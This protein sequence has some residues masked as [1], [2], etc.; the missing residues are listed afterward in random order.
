MT[1]HNSHLCVG[2][3]YSGKR[4]DAGMNTMFRVLKRRPFLLDPSP[5]P[6]DLE[7]EEVIYRIER[8]HTVE[9]EVAFWTPT[10]QSTIDSIKM[11][12]ETYELMSRIGKDHK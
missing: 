11:L 7:T 2:G 10:S 12:L 4:H 1:V 6:S 5:M 9:G 3:P 8:I